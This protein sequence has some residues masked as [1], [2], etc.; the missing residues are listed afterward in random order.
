MDKIIELLDARRGVKGCKARCKNAV[1]VF[2]GL[3]NCKFS[4]TGK[5][6]CFL[7]ICHKSGSGNTTFFSRQILCITNLNLIFSGH[8][9]SAADLGLYLGLQMVC[10]SGIATGIALNLEKFPIPASQICQPA[11]GCFPN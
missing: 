7:Q 3:I 8:F 2:S 6:I 10:P 4:V 5:S 9:L 11:M 1:C